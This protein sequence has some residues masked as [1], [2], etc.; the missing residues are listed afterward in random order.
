MH[1]IY[2]LL[3]YTYNGISYSNRDG[4]LDIFNGTTKQWVPVCD[5]RFTER[6]AEVVCHQLGYNKVNIF[7]S[8]NKRTEMFPSALIR[9]RSWPD[10]IQCDGK[11]PFL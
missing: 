5:D 11:K 6:N 7:Y 1:N 2:E 3:Y 8:R 9:I 4:F 10:P